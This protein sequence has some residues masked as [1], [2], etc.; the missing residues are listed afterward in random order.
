MNYLTNGGIYLIKREILSYIPE[1]AF[2]NATDLIDTLIA[3]GEPVRSYK[4]LSYWLDIG[5]HEDFKKA[6]ED[7]KHIK[8]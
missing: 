5:K 7:F 4:L 8:F 6:Q 3:R 1:N 2:F